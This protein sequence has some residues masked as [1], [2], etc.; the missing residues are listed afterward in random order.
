MPFQRIS[1]EKLSGA[2]IRQIEALILKG[3]L[4]PGERLPSERDLADRLGVSRPS[5]REALAE[6][7]ARDLLVSRPGS[8]L[9]VAEVL[10][11]VFSKPLIRLFSTHTEALFDYLTFRRDLEGLAAER[12]AMQAS[13]A[14][15]ELI[16][17]I[18]AKLEAAEA[19]DDADAAAR[20]DAEFH[21]AITEA[22]HNVIMLH[23][24]R[25]MFEMLREGVF[26]NRQ[27]LFAQKESR[28]ALLAQHRAINDALQSRSPKAARDAAEAHLDFVESSL[29]AILQSR[30]NDDLARLKIQKEQARNG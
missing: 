18:F 20:I 26:Y 7:E 27:P 3:L 2:V 8:G 23:M 15:L 29:R 17:R 6:L 4:R 5:L 13:A 9:F 21:M 19:A 24:M 14:D 30:K 12:A 25:S 28:A 10:G 11:S 22:S 1:P 16:D